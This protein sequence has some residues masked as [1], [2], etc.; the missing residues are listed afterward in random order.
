M[1]DFEFRGGQHVSVYIARAWGDVIV[2]RLGQ[3]P[4]PRG[5]AVSGLVEV[6]ATQ[7]AGCPRWFKLRS[8]GSQLVGPPYTSTTDNVP[9][10]D[11]DQL[12]R[13]PRLE[14]AVDLLPKQREVDGL[15]Q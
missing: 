4:K 13:R 3:D 2:A 7:T 5:L 12:A 11:I 1:G 9:Q 8:Q 6:Q 15:G 14:T 10:A